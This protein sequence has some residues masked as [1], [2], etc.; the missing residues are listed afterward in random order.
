MLTMQGRSKEKLQTLVL[1]TIFKISEKD[2]SQADILR[3]A[4][5]LLN[6][7]E[8]VYVYNNAE[9]EEDIEV[10]NEKGNICNSQFFEKQRILELQRI[11]KK[12]LAEKSLALVVNKC[13]KAYHRYCRALK[14][15]RNMKLVLLDESAIKKPAILKKV[16]PDTQI[17]LKE[18]DSLLRYKKNIFKSIEEKQFVIL[19]SRKCQMKMAIQLVRLQQEYR[20]D[21]FKGMSLQNQIKFIE[22]YFKIK[23]KELV[24]TTKIEMT[25]Q[26]VLETSAKKGQA[27]TTIMSGYELNKLKPD[28][29]KLN[30]K[31]AHIR[32][33]T[34]ARIKQLGSKTGNYHVNTLVSDDKCLVNC[35]SF[36]HHP[37]MKEPL[38]M[39]LAVVKE[40]TVLIEKEKQQLFNINQE[41]NYLQHHSHTTASDELID[42]FTSILDDV[43]IDTVDLTELSE[44]SLLDNLTK[45]TN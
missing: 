24:D 20:V 34:L 40:Q 17:L 37:I 12:H 35:Q 32:V 22:E 31:T 18:L 9:Y 23:E 13:L 39:H 21:F 11:Q 25:L 5:N 10:F 16:L 30:D 8:K 7:I 27:D 15:L 33:Q 41:L 6:D 44:I 26:H 19:A 45:K 36:E 28:I 14:I 42:D 29:T 38:E 4:S 2:I 1:H 3:I 43:N